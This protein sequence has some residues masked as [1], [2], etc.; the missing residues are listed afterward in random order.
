[1]TTARY[2]DTRLSPDNSPLIVQI[3]PVLNLTDEQF[4][5][6]CQLNAELRIERAARGEL[7]IMPPAGWETSE[8]NA[9]ISMQLRQWAKRDGTGT[10]TD[11]SGGFIL[12]NTTIRSPDAAWIRYDRLAS[13]TAEQRTKFLPLCPDF[14]IELR[15]PTDSLTTLQSKM[16]EYIENGVR[17]GWLID[18][19]QGQVY[20]YSPDSP[21]MR[22]DNPDSLSGDPLLPGFRLDLS[23]IW[24]SALTSFDANLLEVDLR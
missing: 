18:P 10:T 9:E 8:Q 16:L 14:V 12:P 24:Q 5:E 15:S 6:F 19:V 7:L 13:L 23:E 20:V 1:M 4:Y 21:V 17:L 22:L 11:S 2:A 3:Q